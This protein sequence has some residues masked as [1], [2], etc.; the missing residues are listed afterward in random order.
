MCTSDMEITYASLSIH[1][2]ASLL[3]LLVT[4]VFS[5]STFVHYSNHHIVMIIS[6]SIYCYEAQVNLFSSVTFT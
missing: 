4:L 5:V 3:L 6:K 2:V 1:H